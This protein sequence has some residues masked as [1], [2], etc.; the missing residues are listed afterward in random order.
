MRSILCGDALGVPAENR[1][2]DLGEFV[3]R[4]QPKFFRMVNVTTAWSLLAVAEGE[5]SYMGN[6]G[7]RDVVGER[8]TWDE[9]VSNASRVAEGD[10][11]LVRDSDNILGVGWIAHI[12]RWLGSKERYRCIHCGSTK[13][14][15]RKTKSPR[16]RCGNCK[17]EFE[18]P[19]VELLRDIT[20]YR[21]D[22]GSTWRVLNPS[23]HKTVIE[24]A[25]ISDARQNAIREL[26][27]RQ[28]RHIIDSTQLLGET[29]WSSGG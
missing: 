26:D 6:A 28:V 3:D 8:Y 19:S 11:V 29:W 9:T 13:F 25:A 21:A 2:H 17:S 5:R 23:I 1:P 14:K 4:N 22:Y 12:E 15:S 18:V 20:F 7:Y 24:S 27:I 16:Y 10:L